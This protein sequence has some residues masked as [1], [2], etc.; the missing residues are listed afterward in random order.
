MLGKKNDFFPR[1]PP[2]V[3]VIDR[4]LK[5]QVVPVFCVKFHS[6]R[7]Y[8]I[9]MVLSQNLHD[10]VMFMGLPVLED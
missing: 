3:D 5:I 10:F 6:L 7:N 1:T 8:G 2:G 4:R 9:Y